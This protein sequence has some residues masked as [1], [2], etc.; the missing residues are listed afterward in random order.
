MKAGATIALAGGLL[1]AG[2]AL[3]E[4]TENLSE[5][6]WCSR[7]SGISATGVLHKIRLPAEVLD[8][9]RSYPM[10]IRIV[11][12]ENQPWP[13]LIWSRSGDGPLHPLRATL[14]NETVSS[15][16][17]VRSYRMVADVHAKS[18]QR[19]NQVILSMSGRNFIRRAEVW[20]GER[21]GRTT[22]LAA[23]LVFEQNKP[24]PM[25]RRTM[26]YPET[27]V[28]YIEI[29][30]FPDARGATRNDGEWRT[31]EFMLV[32]REVDDVERVKYDMIDPPPDEVPR[33]GV[34]EIYLAAEYRNQPVIYFDIDASLKN[35]SIPVRVYGRARDEGNWR[36]IAD[37]GLHYYDG[38]HFARVMMNRTD[39]QRVKIELVH[40]GAPPPRVTR[41]T[42]GVV[43]HYLMFKPGSADKANLYYGAERYQL[44]HASFIGGVDEVAVV[45]APE[46][47]LSRRLKNPARTVNSLHA[48]R[49]TLL[50]FGLVIVVGSALLALARWVRQRYY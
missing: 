35:T 6:D 1:V 9:L 49:T 33:D 2:T 46:A 42:A 4:A 50:N 30:L 21:A 12:E 47:D 15:N 29:K 45:G 41:V 3:V 26:E 20:G 13:A 34:T 32:Q 17:M 11:D 37:G 44:P 14:E 24:V 23:G 10:D 48:Y 36:W 31:T 28:P 39:F 16:M 38:Q 40:D 7:V 18:S 27:D 25:R 43:P 5:Y 22:L 19:H 8:G